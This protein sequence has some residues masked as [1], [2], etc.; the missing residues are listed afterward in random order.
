MGGYNTMLLPL[1]LL[2][3]VFI[4]CT[5]GPVPGKWVD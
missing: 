5:Q 1:T 3:L 4:V 2:L